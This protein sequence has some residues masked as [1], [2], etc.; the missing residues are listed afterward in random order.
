MIRSIAGSPV[1]GDDFFGRIA[2]L[3][4]L[5]QV[6][7]GQDILLLGPRRIGKTSVSRRL[8]ERANQSGYCAFEVNVASCADEAGFVEKL[9]EAVGENADS[10]LKGKATDWLKGLSARASAIRKIT[11][12]A[13]GASASVDIGA[14]DA[15]SWDKLATELLRKLAGLHGHW[16]IYVDELPIFLYRLLER[17]S[18]NTDRV[19]RFLDWFRNDIREH[20]TCKTLHWL[21]SGSVGLDT[22][23]QRCRIPDTINTLNHQQLPPFDR[24]EEADPFLVRLSDDH[25]LGLTPELRAQLLDGIGWTQ[26][27]FIQLVVQQLI[28]PELRKETNPQSRIVRALD[29]VI[30]SNDDNDFH[31][32]ESRLTT[33]LGE[34]DAAIAGELLMAV[35]RAPQGI[36]GE[37]LFNILSPRL[38]SSPAEQKRKFIEIRDILLRD[39]YIWRD[40]AE[41]LPRYRFRFELLRRWWL[42]RNTL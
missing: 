8:C 2:I 37:A 17:S 22:L 28:R 12:A 18:G 26:P 7:E 21:I 6:L 32:W 3:E 27:F 15:E 36:T 34:A 31:H 35:A 14:A 16:L 9:L 25:G 24:D 38:P 40:E 42:K 1:E 33:Q 5:W 10:L 11:F 19:R 29:A 30:D 41:E 4:Y 20:Q 13:G 39:A 23:V